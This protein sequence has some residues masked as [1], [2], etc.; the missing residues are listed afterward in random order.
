MVVG[1]PITYG[2]DLTQEEA[3][4]NLKE[5]R[6]GALLVLS[7]YLVLKQAAYAADGKPSPPGTSPSPD[8]SQIEIY[9]YNH[10]HT[11][12]LS[13]KQKFFEN[14]LTLFYTTSLTITKVNFWIGVFGG[15]IIIAVIQTVT[16][17]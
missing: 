4:K 13:K 7:L 11:H 16:Q 8:P 3:N 2:D 6:F 17:D 15:L 12:S 9:P 14:F 10:T 1:Y 5:V